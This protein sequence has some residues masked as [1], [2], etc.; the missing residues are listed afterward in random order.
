MSSGGGTKGFSWASAVRRAARASRASYWARF[1]RSDETK[2]VGSTLSSSWPAFHL[3]ALAD[4]DLGD[5][6]AVEALHHLHLAR[7]DD[8]AFAAGDFVEGRRRPT[9]SAPARPRR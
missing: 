2:R 6:A 4:E 3:L 5:D 1:S 7:R 9:R 8:L